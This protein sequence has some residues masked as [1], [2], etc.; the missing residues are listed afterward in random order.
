[1]TTSREYATCSPEET[2]ALAARL[3]SH[4]PGGVM[5]GLEGPVGAGKTLFTQGLARGLECLDPDLVRSPTFVLRMDHALRDGRRLIHVDAYRLSGELEFQGL[6]IDE[7]LAPD[8]VVVVEWYD[9]VREALPTELVHVSLAV[10]GSCE[11]RIRIRGGPASFFSDSPEPHRVDPVE[12][13]QDA[14]Q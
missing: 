2:R 13:S 9:Q 1:M 6:G 14:P 3:G 11:R 8:E 5:V 7:P 12:R 10:V 4:L